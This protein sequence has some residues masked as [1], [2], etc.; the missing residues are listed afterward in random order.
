MDLFH[1]TETAYKNGY[2]K[3][4]ADAKSANNEICNMCLRK[5]VC[6]IFN[7]TGGVAQCKYFYTKES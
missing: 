7:A 5:P 4:Y 1:V 2:E 3:G 6:S